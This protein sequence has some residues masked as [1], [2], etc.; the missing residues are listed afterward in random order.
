GVFL[1]TV[2]FAFSPQF[3]GKQLR[4]SDIQ[5]YKGAAKESSD[6]R[7]ETGKRANWTGTNFS[8]MPTFQLSTVSAGNQL[9]V[10]EKPLQAFLPRPAGYFFAGMLCAYLLLVLIGVRPW[11]AIAGA[12]G[13]G[14]ATN[15]L[16]LFETGHMTKLLTTFY[17]PL[18]AAGILLAFKEKYLLG[19]LIFALGM[20]LSIK[21][22][23][24][25]MVY[26]FG[27][28]LP[29]FGV[30]QF[31]HDLKAG[32]LA[33]F[34]KA[35]GV[36][37]AGLVLAVGA[38]ASN[39]LTTLDYKPTSMRG[40]QV[41][42]T[43]LAAPSGKDAPANGLE[44]DYAMQ[45]SNGIKDLVATYAPLA[46][47]GSNGQE[48]DS[49]TDFGKAM[50]QA[51][52]NIRGAFSAPLYH[53]AL[54]FTEGPA[55]LGAV[56]WAL[57]LFGLFTARR[58]LAI[59]LGGGTFFIFIISMGKNMEGIN[60]FLYDTLPLLNAF[61]APSSA[62]TISSMMMVVLGIIGVH[63]WLKTKEA[64]PEK[65]KKQLLYSGITAVVLGLVVAFILPSLFGFTG[66][67]DEALLQRFTQG[68][69]QNIAPLL[70]GLESTRAALYS[71]DAWRSLLFVG[72]TFGILF[73]LFRKT[74]SPL[75]GGLALAALLLVDFSGINGREVSKADWNKVPRRA[76]PF[77]P[78]AADQ[79]ILQDKDPNY[80][81][82]NLTVSSFQDASTS[83]FHKNI[84]GYSAVKM[85]RYEDLKNGYLLNR[86]QDVLNMLNTRYFII[87][88]QDGQPQ[89]QRNPGAY[90]PAWLVR[91]IQ[92]VSTNDA[93]FAALGTVE[94][95]KSTAII[96]EEFADAVSGLN[97]SGQGSINITKYSPDELAYD[98]NSPSEQ[99]V[100]FSEI[101]YGPDL[102]WEVEIDGQA[103]DLIRTNYVLRGLRVPAGQHTITMKF[104]PSSFY[105]GRAI[106]LICSLLILLGIVGYAAYA[107]LKR[108]KV[109]KTATPT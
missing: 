93:E 58:S 41:L 59:W 50:R 88:G 79:Q 56:I 67:N 1:L 48:V 69:I 14:M 75:I 83:Y 109:E 90:G 103:A 78:T 21:A 2:V 17:L 8:G 82:L 81:V 15:G 91:N 105:T 12:V 35:T 27:L 9:K 104:A 92:S 74:I 31:I 33:H 20:G 76:T 18:I 5:S 86:D 19:G 98:F 108:D 53:G 32:R 34:A 68:Q 30:A 52:F 4:M 102:G 77:Q 10:V 28:T 16:V 38:G 80:R 84:G 43:P 22:N 39:L 55:Y 47:G 13:A 100:V 61:R 25:Q 7:K 24:P 29:F 87:P 36:L 60:H 65:A 49:S 46:A 45:W 72:L 73:L 42:E 106:S 23:H 57:F 3:Q 40:G 107:Y 6:Y 70:D 64:T 99:L 101:W 11:L 96:H 37:V 62:L 89:A 97:P 51:G 71:A 63:D 54:P 44:W 94:D 95:L 85:R 66:A 26:Y